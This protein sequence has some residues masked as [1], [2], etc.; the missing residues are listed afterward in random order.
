MWS[1]ES[2]KLSATLSKPVRRTVFGKIMLKRQVA[3]QQVVKRLLVLSAIQAAEYDASLGLLSSQVR[4]HASS[5]S[6]DSE[7]RLGGGIGTFLGSGGGISP[8]LDKVEHLDP[9]DQTSWDRSVS[10]KVRLRLLSPPFFVSVSW[11][12]DAV[13]VEKWPGQAEPRDRAPRQGKRQAEKNRSHKCS[14]PTSSGVLSATRDWACHL[15]SWTSQ[16]QTQTAP[17][18]LDHRAGR[19]FR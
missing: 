17:S 15:T 2:R 8:T 10:R 19:G 11:Q 9:L 12:V 14:L 6:K 5:C 7:T 13:I 16:R 4:R 3:R 18:S 1:I